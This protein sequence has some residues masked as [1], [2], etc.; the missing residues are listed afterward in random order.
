MGEATG[1]D[2]DSSS[3]NDSLEEGVDKLTPLERGDPANCSSLGIELKSE[4][5]DEEDVTI[6]SQKKKTRVKK[7][8][9][10]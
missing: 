3:T 6:R 8:G 9:E 7:V 1:K 4:T 2:F 10:R 5:E